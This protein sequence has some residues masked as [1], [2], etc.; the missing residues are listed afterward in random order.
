[1]KKIPDKVRKAIQD[2]LEERRE[3]DGGYAA[4][5]DED[6]TRFHEVMDAII[7]AKWGSDPDGDRPINYIL[8]DRTKYWPMRYSP[9]PYAHVGCP[10]GERL[11]A[12][13]EKLA[14]LNSATEDVDRHLRGDEMERLRKE[15]NETEGN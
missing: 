9:V 12:F 13:R 14:N 1:M 15:K 11:E 3:S 8:I 10:Q 6:M 5:T 7:Q 4:V 2:L